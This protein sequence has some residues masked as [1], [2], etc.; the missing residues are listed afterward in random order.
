M[1]RIV[2]GT[3]SPKVFRCLPGLVVD[4]TKTPSDSTLLGRTSSEVFVMLVVVIL[5]SLLFFIHWCFCISELLLH[6]TGTPSWLLRPLKVSTGSELYTLAT[7]DCFCFFIYRERYGFEWA[8]LP[9]DIFYLTLLS[10]HFWLNILLSTSP[11]EPAGLLSNLQDFMRI[12]EI[13]T[14]PIYLF[15]SQ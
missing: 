3:N 4:L 10:Q 1:C 11:W 13:Q 14:R 6:A 5:H 12:L 15:D 2:S 7:L 8:F 9:T